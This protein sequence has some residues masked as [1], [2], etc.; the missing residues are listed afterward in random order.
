MPDGRGSG[1]GPARG[2]RARAVGALA[3]A[4]ALGGLVSSIAT[5]GRGPEATP[6]RAPVRQQSRVERRDLVETAAFDGMLGYAGERPVLAGAAGTLTYAAPEGSGVKR[7]EVLYSVDGAPVRLLYGTVPAY[8][9]LGYS[10]SDGRDVEQLEANLVALGYDPYDDVS[11]DGDW[12][13]ATTAAVRRWEDARDVVEDGLVSR[14]E[15]V[16][17]PRAR[18]VGDHAVDAGAPV[19]PGAQVFTTSSRKRVVSVDVEVGDAH[20]FRRKSR[21]TVELPNGDTARGRVASVARVATPDESGSGGDPTI[22]VTIGL[23]RRAATGGIDQAPV[24]VVVEID[25][26]KDVLAVPVSALLATADGFAVEVVHGRQTQLVSV[27][28]GAYADGWVEI[29]GAAVEE[30]T[31][32][33]VAR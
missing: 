20:L 22:A 17:L 3:A 7:G 31:P 6:D 27:E 32:V 12:D 28:P 23:R 2:R 14:G 24:D 25:R 19:T 26:A 16:F 29:G 33:V 11:V 18:I 4:L 15:I 1:R 5:A 13:S 30:G 10:V 8:R 21:V 9:D